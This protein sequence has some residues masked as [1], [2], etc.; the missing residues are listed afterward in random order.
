MEDKS[1]FFV[2]KLVILAPSHAFEFVVCGIAKLVKAAND[3][4]NALSTT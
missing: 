1:S 4:R 2:R 3:A